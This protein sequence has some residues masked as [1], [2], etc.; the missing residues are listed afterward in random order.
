MKQILKYLYDKAADK[1]RTGIVT[2][3]PYLEKTQKKTISILLRSSIVIIAILVVMWLGKFT[4]KH[5][6]NR[7]MFMVSPVTFSFETPTWATDKFIH[8][9]KNLPGLKKKYNMFEKDL[10]KKIAAIYENSPLI[11]KVCYIERE[12]PNCINL[13]FELHRPI[14]IIKNKGKEIL[15]DKDCVRLPGEFYKYPEEGENPI[16]IISS[17]SLRVPK[18]GERCNNRSIREGVNLLNYLKFN[19]IDKLLKIASIDVSN[20]GRRLKSGKSDIMLRTQNGAMIK[21]GCPKSCEQPYELSD[22]GKLQNLLSV[23]KEEGTE[24]AN[25]EYVDVRWKIPFGKHMNVPMKDKSQYHTQI[26]K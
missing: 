10:T 25:M 13:K 5:L 4:W 6:T 16:Y 12:L 3:N 2:L 20:V 18:C 24:L 15:V 11:S 21:W 26:V 8:K 7:A 19:K 9:V 17:R 23:I 14:A 22:Y 1:T